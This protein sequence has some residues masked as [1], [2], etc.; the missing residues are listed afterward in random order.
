MAISGPSGVPLRIPQDVR[1]LLRRSFGAANAEI[2][3]M[4]SRIPMVREDALDQSLISFLDRQA[5]E[6]APHSGWVVDVETH[7]LGGGQHFG[8]WEIADIMNPTWRALRARSR[9]ALPPVAQPL[10]LGP[11]LLELC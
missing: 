2:A 3:G 5:P 9:R 6:V 4:L 1:D 7:F 11:C 8:F 10:Q